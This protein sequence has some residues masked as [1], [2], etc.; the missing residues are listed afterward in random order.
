MKFDEQCLGSKVV[1]LCINEVG[2]CW[3]GGSADGGYF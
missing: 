2:R 3:R 1:W